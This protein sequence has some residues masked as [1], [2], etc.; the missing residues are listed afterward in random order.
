MRCERHNKTATCDSCDVCKRCPNPR[1][2]KYKH[3]T[4]QNQ[5]G[6][7]TAPS[8]QEERD[9]RRA[10]ELV[11]LG[12]PRAQPARAAVTALQPDTYVDDTHE[13][14]AVWRGLELAFTEV[15][16]ALL[17]FM[18]ERRPR[19]SSETLS[20]PNLAKALTLVRCFVEAGVRLVT[21][22]QEASGIVI[23]AFE[24][25]IASAERLQVLT[26]CCLGPA[27]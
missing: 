4:G 25:A 5:S 15:G 22:D 7:S 16:V 23:D 13:F 27:R 8:T 9:Q 2:T 14:K 19:Y 6:W 1:C 3:G 12:G 21:S 20:D 24:D 18:L 17:S 26:C 11:A 10:L